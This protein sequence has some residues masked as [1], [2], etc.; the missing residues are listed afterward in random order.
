LG[1]IIGGFMGKIASKGYFDKNIIDY[2][3]CYIYNKND[4]TETF[5]GSMY[6]CDK[7]N[8]YIINDYYHKLLNK[9]FK[10]TIIDFYGDNY[11]GYIPKYL[12]VGIIEYIEDST[13]VLINAEWQSD[14]KPF[15][16][17]KN[18]YVPNIA[19]HDTLPK[20]K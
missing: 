9:I 7:K 13:I 8:T 15:Y 3:Y 10:D 4:L 12:K 20:I 11:D 14:K 16:Y 5:S 18:V 6:A 19:L 1:S 17:K 2:K